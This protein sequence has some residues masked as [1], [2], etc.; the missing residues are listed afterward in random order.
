MPLRVGLGII[1]FIM[2]L[3]SFQKYVPHKTLEKGENIGEVTKREVK[4]NMLFALAY[5]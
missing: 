5:L 4:K 1:P 2:T 3:L